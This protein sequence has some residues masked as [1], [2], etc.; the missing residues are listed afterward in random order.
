MI[1]IKGL[2]ALQIEESFYSSPKQQRRGTVLL[3]ASLRLTDKH[4]KV[5]ARQLPCFLAP[6]FCPAPFV[7][8]VSRGLQVSHFASVRQIK[9]CLFKDL[10]HNA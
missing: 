5:E 2:G 7:T 6:L 9:S 10:P 3:M 1:A 8:C 4:I